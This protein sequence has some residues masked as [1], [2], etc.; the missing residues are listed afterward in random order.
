MVES[1]LVLSSYNALAA[2]INVTASGDCFEYRRCHGICDAPVTDSINGGGTITNRFRWKRCRALHER[3]RGGGGGGRRADR[4]R[5]RSTFMS[6]PEPDLFRV[7]YQPDPS[8]NAPTLFSER[9]DGRRRNHWPLR[10]EKDDERKKASSSHRW[11]Y[12]FL[13][14]FVCLFVFFVKWPKRSA[15]SPRFVFT[16][17]FVSFVCC[18]WLFHTIVF[19]KCSHLIFCFHA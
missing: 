17:W 1:V 18:R 8:Q 13:H 15:S 10:I 19:L 9:R 7:S 5:S 6:T 14:M 3:E 11:L 16:F 2:V 4:R 12:I